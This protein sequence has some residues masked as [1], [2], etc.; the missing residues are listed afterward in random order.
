MWSEIFMK[1]DSGEKLAQ[2]CILGLQQLAGG[3][4]VET[5]ATAKSQR[6]RN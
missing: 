2:H 1:F 6:M 4:Y 5:A 3:I